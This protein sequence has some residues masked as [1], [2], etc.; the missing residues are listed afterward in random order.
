[1]GFPNVGITLL[2]QN[3]ISGSRASESSRFVCRLSL[4]KLRSPI[5][6]SSSGRKLLRGSKYFRGGLIIAAA[7]LLLGVIAVALQ[8]GLVQRGVAKIEGRWGGALYGYDR[9]FAEEISILISSYLREVGDLPEMSELVIDV[10]FKEMRK[11]YKK[12]EDALARGNLIQ[13]EDDFVKGNI[14]VDGVTVPVK[15]R[16]KGDWN[17]HLAGRKWS[18]RVHVRSGEHIF[19]MR[20][21]SIQTPAARGYQS[22]LM[23]FELLK[24]FGI[25][26]PRYSFAN[27]TLNG[28]PMGIMAI[29]EF[30]AKEL[31]EYNRRR[32]GVIVRFDEAHVWASRDGYP[33][34]NVGWRG[35]FDHYSNA[36]VDAFGSG[37]IAESPSLSNQYAIAVGLLRGFVEGE[38]SATEVFDTK[39]LGRYIAVADLFGSW[40]AIAW[41]NLR[42]YLNPVSMRLEPIAFDATLQDHLEGDL[43][44]IN[45]EPLLLRMMA[46]QELMGEY[47]Q[48]LQELADGLSSGEI[49]ELLRTTEANYLPLLRTEFRLLGEYPLEYLMPRATVL[50]ARFAA[51]NSNPDD[52]LYT[53]V[54]KEQELYSRLAHVR[55]IATAKGEVAEIENAIPKDIELLHIRWVN[56][57]SGIERLVSVE[58]LPLFIPARG[59]ESAAQIWR[60]PLDSV[61]VGEGWQLEADFRL[62]HRT[63]VKTTRAQRSYEPLVASPVPSGDLQEL[64]KRYRFIRQVDNSNELFIKEGGWRVTDSLVVPS[65]YKLRIAGGAT[66]QFGRDALLIINGSLHVDG[67]EVNG[68]VF[69]ALDGVSWPGLL[70]SGAAETS[71]LRYLT[72]RNTTGVQTNGWALTGGVNFYESDVEITGCRFENSMGEDALNIIHS[73]FTI[74]DVLIKGTAS[75]AFDADFSEGAV[76]NSRFVDIGKAGGGDAIDVS[77]SII[78]VTDSQFSEVSDKALS[79]GERS[80][81]SADNVDLSN[82][83]TGAAAKDGS[84]LVLNNS[85]INGASFAGLTAYIKKPEYGPAK[86]TAENITV[87]GV[88]TPVLVQTGSVVTLDGKTIEPEDVDVDA[89]YETIMRKG[90]V[91]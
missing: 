36:P 41:H 25:M 80:E 78:S 91:R 55:L 63:W 38:L 34:V 60:F 14:H 85:S 83:G 28:E 18:F 56:A 30:F 57:D 32:E 39:Q 22:E 44:I 23:F 26:T 16:L 65:G 69:D 43:S 45:D 50:L 46:D 58:Q 9:S 75:D 3:V 42:F 61:P 84:V 70:V 12:R 10:P 21:F 89:L 19:G 33:D 67:T 73:R 24:D 37:R 48:A 76:V 49:E 5:K 68:V 54:D 35:A 40:H 1:M 6:K 90:F 79:V 86:I 59:I 15:L 31:L 4:V 7:L 53:R 29:E 20:R 87:S 74:N 11:I 64:L 17:D 13:G 72:V 62:R 47:R 77:G 82:V 71:V 81:M 88:P 52:E 66:L 2:Y 51:D 27:V 8:P